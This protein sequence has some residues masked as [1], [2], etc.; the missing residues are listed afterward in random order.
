MLELVSLSPLQHWLCCFALLGR[1]EE[2]EPYP[3]DNLAVPASRQ[4]EVSSHDEAVDDHV[5][6]RQHLTLHVLPP[7]PS[8][9]HET[10]TGAVR[11]DQDVLLAADK[12]GGPARQGVVDQD[13]AGGGREV[14]R[15]ELIVPGSDDRLAWAEC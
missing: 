12:D 14:G 10:Q 8:P 11:T 4:Q 2:T 13:G 3:Y 7:F 5:V 1:R 9:H 15:D 6:S